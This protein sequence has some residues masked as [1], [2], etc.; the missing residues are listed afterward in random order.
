MSLNKLFLDWNTSVLDGFTL[1]D[2]EYFFL[3]RGFPYQER[4]IPRNP[5]TPEVFPVMKSLINGILDS[6]LGWG[7]GGRG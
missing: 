1:P 6:L 3:M 5:E 7:G 2:R 4:K